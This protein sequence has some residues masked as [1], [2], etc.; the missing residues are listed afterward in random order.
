M[1]VKHIKKQWTRHFHSILYTINNGDE[2]FD[3]DFD[4]ISCGPLVISH[5]H[6]RKYRRPFRQTDVSKEVSW[7]DGFESDD[8]MCLV[9]SPFFMCNDSSGGDDEDKKKNNN[10]TQI[11][12]VVPRNWY[13]LHGFRSA[14][15]NIVGGQW[16]K[17]AS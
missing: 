3:T 2:I 4:I 1:Y 11:E 17:R 7:W 16:K 6:C 8:I 10:K 14:A 13:S 5:T 15:Y 12:K 9:V